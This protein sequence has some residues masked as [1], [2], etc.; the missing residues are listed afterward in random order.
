MGGINKRLDECRNNISE[1]FTRH[2]SSVIGFQLG[3]MLSASLL[4][5]SYGVI[6]IP[7]FQLDGKRPVL[8]KDRE[9][10]VQGTVLP[11][12]LRIHTVEWQSYLDQGLV[13]R[14]F[15]NLQICKNRHCLLAESMV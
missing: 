9:K 3:P 8:V 10:D 14:S 5:T 11:E 12:K 13:G 7:L 1:N 15:F 4:L 6:N 2:K